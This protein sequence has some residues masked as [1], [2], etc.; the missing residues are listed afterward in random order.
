MKNKHT[1]FGYCDY[2]DTG[3]PF[4]VGIGRYQ[5][6]RHLQRNTKHTNIMNK[7]GLHRVI[8]LALSGSRDDIWPLLCHWEQKTIL[9][10]KTQHDSDNHTIGCN[11]TIGGDGIVGFRW[12]KTR[13]ECQ[14]ISESKT[15]LYQDPYERSK[16]GCAIHHAKMDPVK[17]RNHCLGQQRRYADP[18]Q[19]HYAHEAN[20]QKKRVQQLTPDGHV[21]AEFPSASFAIQSTGVKN[22]KSVCQ[23]KRQFAGGFR[24]RYINEG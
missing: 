16:L 23:G 17:Y 22:I 1:L 12:I 21:I 9:E 11:F 14:K 6:V 24:W 20:T 4:Y 15:R 18:V 10:R 13:E 8:E 19:R 5:R 2:T 3:S 7:Y